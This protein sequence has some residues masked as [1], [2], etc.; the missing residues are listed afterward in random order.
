MER[1]SAAA[2]AKVPHLKASPIKEPSP[3][4]QPPAEVT[5]T[6]ISGKS[7]TSAVHN[8]ENSTRTDHDHTQDGCFED[9]GYLSLH[10]SQ[11]DCH[12]GDEEDDHALEKPA[13]LLSAAGTHP[14][15]TALLNSSPSKCQGWTKSSHQTISTPVSCPKRRTAAL[16]ST[17]S[18][19]CT[20][21][22][23]PILRFQQAVC[24][25]LSKSYRKNKK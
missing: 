6:L 3:I 13:V 24:D 16:S 10:T 4:K 18:D 19:Q 23:L 14:E 1:S 25:E 9:S 11:I 5:A 21:P 8:K 12:H 7:R 2:D 20:D 22:N 17:P 15:K